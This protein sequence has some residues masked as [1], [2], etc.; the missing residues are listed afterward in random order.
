MPVY[1]L[2]FILLNYNTI[3]NWVLPSVIK[4]NKK[5]TAYRY[6]SIYTTALVPTII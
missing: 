6:L 1:T 2:L 5:P 4:I 3:A